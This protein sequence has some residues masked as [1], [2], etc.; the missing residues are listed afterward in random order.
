MIKI[1]YFT[2]DIN[3]TKLLLPENFVLKVIDAN[4]VDITNIFQIYL[5]E[6]KEVSKVYCV[7]DDIEFLFILYRLYHNTFDQFTYVSSD[8]KAVKIDK[9]IKEKFLQS[10]IQDKEN[11][12]K[13][14][15]IF[16]DIDVQVDYLKF[17]QKVKDFISVQKGETCK[18]LEVPIQKVFIFDNKVL[19]SEF[20][21]FK[22]MLIFL[23]DSSLPS[24]INYKT[25]FYKIEPLS[26]WLED[27]IFLILNAIDE[28][29]KQIT[30]P[31]EKRELELN[32]LNEYK[33]KKYIICS[34]FFIDQLYKL[35]SVKYYYIAFLEQFDFFTH[36]M[37][38]SMI[39]E[40]IKDKELEAKH[41]FFLLNQY[42]RLDFTNKLDKKGHQKYLWSLYREV[43]E[44]YKIKF[45]GIEFITKEKRNKNLIIIV[46]S[47]FLGELHAPTKLVLERA[48][49]LVKDF[50][51]EV[52]IINTSELLSK[53]GQVPFY[54]NYL[55]YKEDD[56]SHYNSVSYKD[57]NIPF[58]QSS[59]QMPN[60]NEIL[61]ILSIVN[62]YKPYFILSIG[63]ANLTA[64]LCSNLVTTVTFPTTSNFPIS[65][66]QVHI[67][68]S[69]LTADERQFLKE[70]K[71]DPKSVIISYPKGEELTTQYSYTRQDFD[72]PEDKFLISVVGN[73]LDDEV[74]EEFILAL[75]KAIEYGAYIGFIG[76]FENYDKI[77]KKYSQLAINSTFLG[78]QKHLY[79][80][81]KVFDL[82]VNPGRI[83]GGSGLYFLMYSKPIVTFN[84][85]DVHVGSKGLFSVAT[86]KDME[87]KI[88][89]NITDEEYY[90]SQTILAKEVFADLINIHGEVEEL[91]NKI[92][93]NPNFR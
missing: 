61:N 92:E 68:R 60:E 28:A 47:Q 51:K 62:E 39:E 34:K 13:S 5:E 2:T 16:D 84:Y 44:S 54:K 10:P 38:N 23:D 11:I 71:I 87:E 7:S 27:E 4:A 45:S 59:V 14:I 55:A 81:M 30:D 65:M 32:E 22:F 46:T 20:F 89:K 43:F 64:D 19:I 82:F 83:G 31:I 52:L 3:K 77:C 18:S 15:Y 17:T 53:E 25:F 91:L 21:S 78:Y 70:L 1:V 37:F 79:D 57:I 26:W 56:F 63:T 8:A 48:Y 24:K 76:Q 80:V 85:G 58:Y 9:T 50:N 75:I 72:L 93:L 29:G 40:T 6:V 12:F 36:T 67:Y 69:E 88:I 73:R 66:S 33:Q 42:I 41:K 74:K 35:P 90:Y 49:H 86:Y